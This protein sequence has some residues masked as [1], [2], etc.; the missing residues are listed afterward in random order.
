ME[1]TLYFCPILIELE[2]SE[3]IFEKFSNIN[4]IFMDPCIVV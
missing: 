2:S 3:Q 1:S 4:L